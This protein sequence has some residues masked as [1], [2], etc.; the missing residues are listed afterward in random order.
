MTKKNFV[1]NRFTPKFHLKTGDKV[2]VLSGDNRG[3]TG[4]I[5]EMLTK[6][7]RAIVDGLNMVSKHIKPTENSA[8]GIVKK[9]APIHISNL[10][11]VDPKSGKG[12][13]IG[14]KSVDGKS[15][16][17]SKKTGEIIK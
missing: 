7:N 12:T 8:G 9:E 1:T 14:R 6:E 5:R 17:Y 16:R 3:E 13:R 2:I 10:Q 11:L 4:V 15:V